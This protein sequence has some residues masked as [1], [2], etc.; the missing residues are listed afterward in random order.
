MFG[1]RKIPNCLRIFLSTSPMELEYPKNIKELA[2]WNLF[3]S[4]MKSLEK[5]S[6]HSPVFVIFTPFLVFLPP[7]PPLIAFRTYTPSNFTIFHCTDNIMKTNTYSMA[8]SKTYYFFHFQTEI[9]L[10]FHIFSYGQ[11]LAPEKMQF[12]CKYF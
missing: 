12:T 3:L 1:P 10:F 8:V 11:Y 2:E 6:V 5:I 9:C 4:L 7:P